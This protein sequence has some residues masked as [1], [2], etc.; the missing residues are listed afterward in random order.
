M[1]YAIVYV[2]PSD[3]NDAQLGGEKA[4]TPHDKILWAGTK[5][6]IRNKIILKR[7]YLYALYLLYIYII[8]DYFFFFFCSKVAKI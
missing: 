2:E 5:S 8:G 6:Q 7:I 3:F 1:L 4:N